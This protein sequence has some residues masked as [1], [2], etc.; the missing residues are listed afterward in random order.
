MKYYDIS[1]IVPVYNAEKYLDKCIKSLLL[2]RTKLSYC[3]ILVNDGSVDLSFKICEKY[4]KE[5][6]NVYVYDKSNGG[7]STA[8]NLGIDKANSKY[9][10]FVDSDDYVDELYISCLFSDDYE[11]DLYSAGYSILYEKNNIKI[12]NLPNSSESQNGEIGKLLSAF[13]SEGILNVDVGKIYL[14]KLINQNSIRFPIDMTTGEDLVFNCKYI[15]QIS[16]FK[17][18]DKSHYYY[19][20]RDTESLVNSYKPNLTDMINKCLESVITLF[21]NNTNKENLK[22]I[23]N[24]YFD[25]RFTEIINLFRKEC[26]LRLKEKIKKIKK[27]LFD[28]KLREYIKTSSREDSFSKIFKW[29]I[30]HKNAIL[31]FCIFKVLF[32]IRYNFKS[33]Y[34]WLRK[35]IMLNDKGK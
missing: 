14:L 4:S 30:I 22:Y 28:E 16:S 8:K 12:D 15:N 11:Y 5:Y 2:Q 34:Y 19:V 17:V 31:S 18:I 7:T 9:I 32:F 27:I 35:K 29:C 3:I 23:S 25:Y 26:D 20:R 24:I 13:K 6:T 1:I 10:M 33:I 21:E